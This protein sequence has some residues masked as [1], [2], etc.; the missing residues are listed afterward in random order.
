[1]LCSVQRLSLSTLGLSA[2]FPFTFCPIWRFLVS[3]RH[4]FPFDVFYY[5]TFF[6]S[7]F[8]HIWRFIR[9]RFLAWA[10]YTSTFCRWLMY[11]VISGSGSGSGARSGSGS[12]AASGSGYGTASKFKV[13]CRSA[14]KHRR[15]AK[16]YTLTWSERGSG[17]IAHH[18]QLYPAS[19]SGLWGRPWR[20][21][22]R[23]EA[24]SQ[25]C[26]KVRHLD[27]LHVQLL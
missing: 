16:L 26:G 3:F 25:Q 13:G 24:S 12:G 21:E 8:C 6:P 9:R 18:P 4:Y 23:E 20:S 17:Q 5:P 10:F 14:S 11:I 1:M 27:I 22:A 7:T 19:S 2:L 15:T